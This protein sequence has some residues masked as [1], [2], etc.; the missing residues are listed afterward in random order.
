VGAIF[1]DCEEAL[2][3]AAA[4]AFLQTRENGEFMQAIQQALAKHVGIGM[5]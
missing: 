1:G 5:C 4:P 2:H 3:N